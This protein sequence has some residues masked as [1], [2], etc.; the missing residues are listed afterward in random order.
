[1]YRGIILPVVDGKK[2]ALSPCGKDIDCGCL[3][4]VYRGGGFYIKDWRLELHN[5]VCYS[6]IFYPSLNIITA[7]TSRRMRW[8]GSV[9]RMAMIRNAYTF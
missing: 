7:R 4:R 2:L 3:R 6:A 8:A 9:A 5:K 1:M